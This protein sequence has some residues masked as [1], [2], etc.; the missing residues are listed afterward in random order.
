MGI[1]VDKYFLSIQACIAKISPDSSRQHDRNELIAK[2]KRYES[3]SNSKAAIEM[4]KP[5]VVVR[6]DIF[7]HDPWLLNTLA[8]CIDLRTGELIDHSDVKNKFLT[9]LAPVAYDCEAECPQW[10]RFIGQTFGGNDRLIQYV[11]RLMGCCLT[12]D[13]SEQIMPIFHGGGANGKSVLLDTIMGIL[14]DYATYAPES[15]LTTGGSEHPTEIADLRGRR[16]VVASETEEG[17]G[18][19]IALVKR[20]TGDKSLKGRF[21]HKDFFEFNRTH[22]TIMVTNNK[23]VVQES[24]NATWRRLKLVP[25][26][27]TIPEADQDKRLLEKLVGEWPGILAWAVKG[28]IDWQ[29]HGLDEPKEVKAATDNYRD[30][31]N[32]VGEFKDEYLCVVNPD[33]WTSRREV[34]AAYTHWCK[35]TGLSKVD[36]NGLYERLVKLGFEDKYSKEDG[37]TGRGFKGF[38]ILRGNANDGY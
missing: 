8:G 31:Q 36:V 34:R 33:A 29:Q 7:D 16:L 14:G 21:M 38:S 6:P 17:K 20:L 11:Q 27:I 9:R 19:R 1:L 37:K 35:E 2:A 13:I 12:G 28:C 23:P 32:T 5:M 25:F 22:K 4:L 26:D 15:L 30:E 3:S 18:L 24:K 10:R